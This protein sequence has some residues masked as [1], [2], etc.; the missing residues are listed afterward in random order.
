[1]PGAR[2]TVEVGAGRDVARRD[3][4][5]RRE[6]D[7]VRDRAR[8]HRRVAPP[9]CARSSRAPSRRARRRRGTT[10][11]TARRD[12]A[13][14]CRPGR[15]RRAASVITATRVVG[16]PA[17]VR[18]RAARDPCRAARAAAARGSSMV[19]IF[20]LPIATPCSFTPCSTPHS[21][22]GCEP[23][24]ATAPGSGMREVLRVRACRP[25][26]RAP[27][28]SRHLA[29]AGR[30]IRVLREHHPGVRTDSTACR[31]QRRVELAE[32]DALV[33]AAHRVQEQRDERTVEDEGDE[34][35]EVR[36]RRRAVEDRTAAAPGAPRRRRRARSPTSSRSRSRSR[37]RRRD[38]PIRNIGPVQ[39]EAG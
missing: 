24:S 6:R 1:M 2:A 5:S 20:S 17:R 34:R 18:A 12:R 37:R 25:A 32:P 30:P 7:A 33:V 11:S 39:A 19:Q 8:R 38:A 16:G 31:T 10:R 9:T 4:S 14:R 3:A 29:L 15:G 36:E 13:R 21:H 28:A 23:T 27:V 22:V 26:V 35:V